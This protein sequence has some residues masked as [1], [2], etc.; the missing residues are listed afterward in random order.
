MNDIARLIHA[1]FE[2]RLMDILEPAKL[3]TDVD[4]YN[5]SAVLVQE[6]DK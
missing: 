3:H 2:L 6:E 4:D 1:I 5:L